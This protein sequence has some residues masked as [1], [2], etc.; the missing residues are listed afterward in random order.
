MTNTFP[1]IPDLNG[2]MRAVETLLAPS[3]SL[4]I[5]AHYVGDLAQGAYDTIYHEH[6]SYWALRP[7]QRLFDRWVSKLRVFN[8]FNSSR[9]NPRIRTA[10]RCPPNR[11]VVE[12]LSNQE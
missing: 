8:A 1:H 10:F 12:E 9:S 5:E 4:V 7:M 6:V 3:G 2:L 11:S